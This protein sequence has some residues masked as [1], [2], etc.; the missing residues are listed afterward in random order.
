MKLFKIQHYEENDLMPEAVFAWGFEYDRHGIYLQL[1]WPWVK[2]NKIFEPMVRKVVTKKRFPT[3]CLD[4]RW[5][6]S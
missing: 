5:H 4:L 6:R 2:E 1:K 3:I